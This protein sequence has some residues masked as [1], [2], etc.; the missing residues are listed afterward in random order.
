M[1]TLNITNRENNMKIDLL[2]SIG[3]V[4]GVIYGP[5]VENKTIKIPEV[6]LHTALSAEGEVYKIQNG[7]KFVFVKFGEIQR[8][9]VS[10]RPLHFSLVQ[11]PRQVKTT[12]DVRVEFT[13]EPEGIKSGGIFVILSDTVQVSG[14]PTK[15]PEKITVDTSRMSINDNITVGDLAESYSHEFLDEL[16]TVIAICQPPQKNSQKETENT[17]EL[18]FDIAVEN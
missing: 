6:E 12:V 9:P 11:L 13:G 14:A 2:R 7:K 15:I 3:V 1:Y 18:P 16:D 4:P 5:D 17:E 10:K 8:H